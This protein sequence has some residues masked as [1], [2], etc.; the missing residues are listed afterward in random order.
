MCTHSVT[1]T[2][3]AASSRCSACCLCP[4]DTIPSHPCESSGVLLPTVASAI[5]SFAGGWLEGAMSAPPAPGCSWL[6]VKKCLW[7]GGH[8]SWV[9]I[10]S[11][12]VQSSWGWM[13]HWA[14]VALARDV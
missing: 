8:A 2:S 13:P 6:L 10:G 7:L 5:V 4:W 9:V 11:A 1:C 3:A 12:H 14:A